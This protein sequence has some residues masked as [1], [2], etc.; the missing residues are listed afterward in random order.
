MRA[1]LLPL[2]KKDPFFKKLDTDLKSLLISWFDISLLDLKEITWNSPAALLER[3]IE[4]EAVHEIRSWSDMKH[5]LRSDRLCFAFFHYK[6][7]LNHLF[8]HF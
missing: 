8:L 5:R 6:K 2:A 7:E 4:Y 1:D 3:L